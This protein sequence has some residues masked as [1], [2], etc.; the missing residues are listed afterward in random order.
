MTQHDE[1][2]TPETLTNTDGERIGRPGSGRR[3][4][5]AVAAGA[6][7]VVAVGGAAWA[8]WSFFATG[9]QPA[10]ALPAGTLAYASVDLDPNGGQKIEALRTLR[11]FPAFKHD[12][13]VGAD[14]DLRKT[15]VDQLSSDAG[16]DLDFGQDVEPWLGSRFAVAAVDTGGATPTAVV[17]LQVTDEAKAATGLKKAAGC[18]GSSE[19]D[20]F[21][22]TD[23][24]ALL[25]E[26]QAVLGRVVKDAA[27]SSLSDDGDFQKLTGEAGDDGIVTAYAAPEAGQA[28]LDSFGDQLEQLD[29]TG[30]ATD[31][32]Q[33]LRTGVKEFRGVAASLKFA[34]GGL[35][36]DVAG[37]VGK[38][39]PSDEAG[40]AAGSL[41]KDTLA[42]LSL[43]FP[44]D[45]ASTYVDQ[46]Q[47]AE[48]DL[49]AQVE[50]E[51]GLSL[52]D[53]L[54]TL[55]GDAITVALGPDFSPEEISNGQPPSGVGLR[56]AGKATEIERVL[57]TLK[58]AAGGADE[59][60]LESDSAGGVVA[61]GPDADYRADLLK[62]GGLG[63]SAPFTTVVE[64]AADASFVLYL[65]TDGSNDW[66]A[67]AAPDDETRSNLEPLAAL[68]MSAW[69]SGDT[70]HFVMKV[71]TD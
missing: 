34:D 16:C 70:G 14:A 35:R 15:I 49:V 67:E 22:I 44:D 24:W 64:H 47:S 65:D 43:S 55:T 23:G 29:P 48:P 62:A 58:D 42:A 37:P 12:L 20:A 11:K 25:G 38:V 69:T 71:T 61:V 63:G 1:S 51:T 7:G 36:L 18:D 32:L 19:G 17:V 45:W 39:R 13:K 56:I 40:K 6:L 28:V 9:A 53:D 31:P 52:P 57:G 3:R 2:G 41:P 27:D 46:M 33:Q 5:A 60:F 30:G 54:E 68:G 59:G 50:R 21:T 10:E 26:D 66:L 8:A 4:A